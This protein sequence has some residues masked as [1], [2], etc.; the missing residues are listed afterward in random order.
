MLKINYVVIDECNYSHTR[1]EELFNNID[2]FN[3]L[4]NNLAEGFYS[5]DLIRIEEL[6]ENEKQ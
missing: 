5:V 2:E 3:T 6:K 1:K 4:V